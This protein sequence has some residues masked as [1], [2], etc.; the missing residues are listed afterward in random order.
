MSA[1]R[2]RSGP[3]A[4]PAGRPVIVVAEQLRRRVPGGTGRYAEGLLD[5]L[6][7]LGANAPSVGVYASRH[8]GPGPDPLGRFGFPVRTSFLPGP[9]LVA[10]W[11]RGWSTPGGPRPPGDAVLHAVSLAAPPPRHGGGPVVVTVHD[12]AWRWHPEATTARGRRWHEAAL[13]RALRHAA[14]FVTSSPVPVAELQAAGAARVEVVPPG[15]DHLPPPDREGAG[16][17]LAGLGVTG[18]F[19]LSVGT[20]EPRKNLRR[21]VAAYALARPRL[22]EPWPLVVVGPAGW[23][24]AGVASG[25]EAGVVVAGRVGDAVL[26]ALYAGA[27]VF[28]YVPI[29]EGFGLPPLEAMA[30]GTPVV[31]SSAVPSTAPG[32][33]GVEPAVR[34]PATT[35]E[36]IADA[37]VT[38]A[39]DEAVR[40]AV[41]A[42]GAALVAPLTWAACAARHVALWGS[43]G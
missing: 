36:A 41:G 33:D 17:L 18:P 22:P 24:D 1:P 39:G 14:A 2:T 16:A 40:G 3:A 43:L 25:T 12:L 10:A 32:P 27:R 42:S 21:L 19:L 13:R 8:R 20:L 4:V 6:G 30:A 38:V 29:A 9:F 23:G 37:I 15:L 31:A 35:V 11:D 28:V 34:V 26:A 5:G 7:A